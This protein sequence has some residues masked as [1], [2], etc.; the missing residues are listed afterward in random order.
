VK[1]PRNEGLFSLGALFRA[2]GYDTVFLYGGY[3]YFDNMNAFFRGNGYRVVDRMSA[4]D[5]DVTFANVWGVADEDLYRWALTEADADHAAGRPFY[6]FIMTTSNHR[7]FTY[8]EGRINIPSHTGRRGAVRYT[9]WAI[10]DYFRQARRR[11][12]FDDT[13]FVV[14]ADH[15]AGTSGRAELP[16]DRYRIPLLIYSPAHLAPRVVDRQSSQIDYA[17]TLLGLL[18][19]SY[20]SRFFGKDILRMRPEEERALIAT[21]ESLG[22]LKGDRLVVLKPVRRF[23]QYRYDRRRGRTEPAAAPDEALLHEAISYYQTAGYLM[24]N[25]LL[26]AV[27]GGGPAPGPRLA[28]GH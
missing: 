26:R 25:R 5:D 16:A 15:C 18:G 22:Y 3:G 4:P 12:W 2:R 21:Y 23:A 1:R 6:Q 14:V 19:W 13:I 17:P 28:G 27:D 20:D 9:D 11:P 10:G 24:E 7:P 8:P